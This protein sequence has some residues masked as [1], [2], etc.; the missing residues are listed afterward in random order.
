MYLI[1]RY[2][3]NTSLV[4]I[5][6][7]SYQYKL[8]PDIYQRTEIERW[9]DMLRHQY[10]Y[11]LQDRFNWWQLNRNDCVIPQG[12]FCQISCT[13]TPPSLRD[14]PNYYSQKK[15][16]PILK[17]NRP[18]YCDIYSQVLHL[19]N[20]QASKSGMNKS[21][22]DNSLYQFTQIL[23][24]VASKKGKLIVKVNPRNTSQYCHNCLSK[25]PK[26]LKDRWHECE[27]GVSIDRDYNSAI[28]IKKLG[29]GIA[30]IKKA[31]RRDNLF[32]EARALC[33]AFWSGVCHHNEDSFS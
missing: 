28:L 22:A 9:L 26:E 21:F 11:L 10:N 6:L 23:E 27:C 15:Q 8:L 12:E 33:T 7:L 25:V 29:L 16:L 24:Q 18:W 13:I 20:G 5:M 31:K 2:N 14:N 30:S 3:S 19:P 32:G 4:D 1:L 17:K